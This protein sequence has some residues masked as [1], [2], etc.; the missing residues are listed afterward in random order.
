MS[1]TNGNGSRPVTVSELADK[2][3]GL[4]WELRCYVLILVLG[5]LLK[6]QL[7]SQAAA[8]AFSLIH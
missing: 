1:A 4:R 8:A 6:F 5:V 7:P 3:N 2:M